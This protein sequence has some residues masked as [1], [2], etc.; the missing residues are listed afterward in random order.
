MKMPMS[1]KRLG[2]RIVDKEYTM[3]NHFTIIRGKENTS[4]MLHFSRKRILMLGCE[5]TQNVCCCMEEKRLGLEVK[6]QK[7][8]CKDRS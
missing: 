5:N 2:D 4:L 7:F 6:L 8:L 3:Q 1:I